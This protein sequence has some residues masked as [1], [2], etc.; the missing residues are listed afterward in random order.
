MIFFCS[1][2]VSVLFAAHL[3]EMLL[4]LRYKIGGREAGSHILDFVS[5]SLLASF[6]PRGLA[7]KPIARVTSRDLVKRDFMLV[8]T[9][10]T[11]SLYAVVVRAGG[12]MAH[13]PLTMLIGTLSKV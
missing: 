4:I 12:N 10:E 1:L 13:K 7:K 11:A 5:L 3:C 2:A 9:A 8:Y 6:N